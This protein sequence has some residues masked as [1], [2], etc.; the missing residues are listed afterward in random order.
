MQFGTRHSSESDAA[1]PF[2]LLQM[3]VTSRRS[4]PQIE[5][6]ILYEGVM[7]VSG[8]R[9]MMG[10]FRRCDALEELAGQGRR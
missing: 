4:C 9:H 10:A 7:V 6:C 3:T 1:D 8:N 2:A 5:Q